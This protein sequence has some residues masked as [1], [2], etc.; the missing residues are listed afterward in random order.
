M[1]AM[2]SPSFTV[3]PTFRPATSRRLP[4]W[5]AVMV[6]WLILSYTFCSSSVQLSTSFWAAVTASRAVVSSMR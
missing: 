4:L 1:V 6:S 5:G 2:V 3:S